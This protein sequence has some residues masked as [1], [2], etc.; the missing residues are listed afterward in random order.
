MCIEHVQVASAIVA[1]MATV[2]MAIFTC[3]LW[4]I[5]HRE[6]KAWDDPAKTATIA[7]TTA[8]TMCGATAYAVRQVPETRL[9]AAKVMGLRG[10]RLL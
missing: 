8:L 1:S 4:R 10:L 3:L 6:H 9:L 7:W 5:Q 2:V